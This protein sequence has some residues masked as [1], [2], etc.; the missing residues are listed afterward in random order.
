MRPCVGSRPSCVRISAQPNSRS[1]C[2][3]SKA[4]AMAEAFPFFFF[5]GVRPGIMSSVS[6]ATASSGFGSSGES[7]G[8]AAIQNRKIASCLWEESLWALPFAK[9]TVLDYSVAW[10]YAAG[11][12]AIPRGHAKKFVTAVAVNKDLFLVWKACELLS[13]HQCSEQPWVW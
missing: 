6:E 5:R 11:L 13:S 12:L 3:A 10:T 7:H 8:F 1:P 2:A 9:P 4:A